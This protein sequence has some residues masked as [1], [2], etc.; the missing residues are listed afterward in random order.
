MIQK[1][2]EESILHYEKV[3]DRV[4]QTGYEMFNVMVD[5]YMNLNKTDET[6]Q[7]TNKIISQLRHNQLFLSVRQCQ[8]VEEFYNQIII[9]KSSSD[10]EKQQ[11]AGR[12]ITQGL[13]D[14]KKE[15][16]KKKHKF[17]IKKWIN[18]K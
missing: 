3:Q 16:H 7:E 14:F 1:N 18:K 12:K 2:K 8:I 11:I 9:F 15:F 13:D 5:A 17:N 10:L 6:W 4:I